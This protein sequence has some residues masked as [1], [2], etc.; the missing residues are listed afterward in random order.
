MREIDVIAAKKR[1][2]QV[3]ADDVIG[4]G[5]IGIVN[6]LDMK[7]QAKALHMR[8]ERVRKG[9]GG[10]DGLADAAPAA[11]SSWWLSMV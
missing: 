7:R 6:V 3:Q 9:T 10:D 1:R 5:I 4:N 2:G 11:C 8:P